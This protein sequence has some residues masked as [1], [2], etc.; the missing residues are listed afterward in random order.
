MWTHDLKCEAYD[1]IIMIII[2]IVYKGG[3]YIYST[4]ITNKE[5][6]KLLPISATVGIL[7]IPKFVIIIC[8]V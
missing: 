1:V 5:E 8:W 3:Y 4:Y 7:N 2:A 6:T